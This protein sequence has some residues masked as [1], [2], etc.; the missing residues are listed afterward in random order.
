MT[1]SERW[2][3]AWRYTFATGNGQ[4]STFLSS[5]SMLGLGTVAG[6]VISALATG[7]E[8]DY[9]SAGGP[10]PIDLALGRD[11]EPQLVLRTTF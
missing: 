1:R 5:L 7:S 2:R 9:A 8:R 10:P 6:H 11:G 3:V 4:L